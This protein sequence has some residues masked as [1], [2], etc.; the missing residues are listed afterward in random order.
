MVSLFNKFLVNN[1]GLRTLATE[2]MVF[3]RH[4]SPAGNIFLGHNDV[5]SKAVDADVT[6]RLLSPMR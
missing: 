5:P 1:A 4:R 2:S 6:G 3:D